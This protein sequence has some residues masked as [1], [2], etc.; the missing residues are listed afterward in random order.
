M[1][2]TSDY[3]WRA[4]RARCG[5]RV[6][7]RGVRTWRADGPAEGW[8]L[9]LNTLGPPLL[10][11]LLPPT[12]TRFLGADPRYEHVSSTLV[13]RRAADAAVGGDTG[14]AGGAA[15]AAAGADAPTCI[16]DLV[17]RAIAARVLRLYA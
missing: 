13:R 14:D 3:V 12:D 11:P 4:A 16:D 17:L 8:L 10:G 6:L 15:A 7:Y 9:L 1:L 2:V 5:A